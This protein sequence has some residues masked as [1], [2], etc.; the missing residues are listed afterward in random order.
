MIFDKEWWA[1]Q[2]A[3][4]ELKKRDI[5]KVLKRIEEETELADPGS[6]EFKRLR[7]SYEQEL[8][9]KKLVKEM[10]FLG[11]PIDKI[12]VVCGMLIIMGFGVALDMDSPKAMKLA[13][14][15]LNLAR[16]S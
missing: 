11:F 8:K 4:K 1:K 3:A 6:E 14:F 10:R 9:N 7:E 16:K 15:V 5:D 12:I 13:T 2:K